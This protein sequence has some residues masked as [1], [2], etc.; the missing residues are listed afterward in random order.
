MELDGITWQGSPPAEEPEL[1]ALPSP[2]AGLLRQLNGFVLR[3]G[4]L[5]VRGTSRDLPERQSIKI[6]TD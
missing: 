6:V 5:H 2:L 3:G 1:S 4:A